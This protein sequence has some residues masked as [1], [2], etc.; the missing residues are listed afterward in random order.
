MIVMRA[1]MLLLG[2]PLVATGIGM[3][4]V[5]VLAFVG[6]PLLVVGLGLVSAAVNPSR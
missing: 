1:L 6:V 3:T 4:M 5:G 2:A